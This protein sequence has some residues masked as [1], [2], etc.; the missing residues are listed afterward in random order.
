MRLPHDLTTI[1]DAV[2]K[3]S[4]S[5]AQAACFDNVVWDESV[6]SD[7]AAQYL[8][9][10]EG[11]DTAPHW[12]SEHNAEYYPAEVRVAR[13]AESTYRRLSR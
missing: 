4:A 11:V 2:H 7:R 12:K 1:A 9:Y 8:R 6:A 10:L 13:R 5:V 3:D